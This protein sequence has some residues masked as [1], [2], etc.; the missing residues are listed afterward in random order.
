MA[1]LS[2][3]D[4]DNGFYEQEAEDKM[5]LTIQDSGVGIKRVEQERLFKLFGCLKST[6][7][8]NT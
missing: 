7:S 5:I 4:E 8:R 2:S 3:D 1:D 6:K